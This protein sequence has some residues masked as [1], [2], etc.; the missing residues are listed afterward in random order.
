MRSQ[1]K[2]YIVFK[3]SS[4]ISELL[5]FF[6]NAEETDFI[7]FQAIFFLSIKASLEFV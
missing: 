4:F 3:K 2:H 1:P 5:N 6:L 7:L